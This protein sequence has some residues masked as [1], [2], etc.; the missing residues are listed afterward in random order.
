MST[1][2]KESRKKRK[3]TNKHEYNQAG[4]VH[5][6][7]MGYLSTGG[8]LFFTD[9]GEPRSLYQPYR[10]DGSPLVSSAG[11]GRAENSQLIP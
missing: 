11:A 4:V 8:D 3:L 1:Y 6:E 2:V 10:M 9:Q 7:M 5:C